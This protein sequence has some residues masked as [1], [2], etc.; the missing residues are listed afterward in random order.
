MSNT[1]KESTPMISPDTLRKINR[2]NKSFYDSHTKKNFGRED[3]LGSQYSGTIENFGNELLLETRKLKMEKPSLDGVFYVNNYKYYFDLKYSNMIETYEQQGMI[4]AILKKDVFLSN[5]EYRIKFED[6]EEI[7]VPRSESWGALNDRTRSKVFKDKFYHT[8]TPPVLIIKDNSTSDVEEIEL[9]LEPYEGFDADYYF[10]NE[11]ATQ[12]FIDTYEDGT[13]ITTPITND[14]AELPFVWICEEIFKSLPPVDFEGNDPTGLPILTIGVDGHNVSHIY[15]LIY[16]VDVLPEQTEPGVWYIIAKSS[17]EGF[18]PSNLNNYNAKVDSIFYMFKPDDE[19]ISPVEYE[20]SYE[21]EYIKISLSDRVNWEIIRETLNSPYYAR[22]S[23]DVFN[24]N[25]SEDSRTILTEAFDI[26]FSDDYIFNPYEGLCE[27]SASGI[28][29][30]VTSEYS[31]NSVPTTNGIIHKL[32]EFDGLPSYFKTMHDYKTHRSHVELYTIRDRFNRFTQNTMDKQTSA[33]ILDSSMPQDDVDNIITDQ[34]PAIIYEYVPGEFVYTTDMDKVVSLKNVL[35]EITYNGESVFGNCNIPSD[36]NKPKFIY[37]GNGVFSLN[38]IEFDSEIET[39]RVYGIT[40]DPI[41]YVNNASVEESMP[42]RTAARMCDIPTTYEQLIHVENISPTYVFD[43][44][45]VRMQ[46]GFWYD[47]LELLMNKRNFKIPMIK[48]GSGNDIWIYPYPSALPSKQILIENGYYNTTNIDNDL[49]QITSDNFR[50]FSGGTNYSIGDT[51][52][53]MLGGKAY[54][55]EV[56][57]VTISGRVSGFDLSIP[58]DS[59]VSIYNIDGTNTT[60]KTATVNT[61]NGTGLILELVISQSD[62]TDHSL[63]IDT[64]NPPENMISFAYDLFDNIFMYRLQSDWT[65]EM[66][67]Q[68]EGSEFRNN[69][70]D[71]NMDVMIRSFNYAFNKLIFDKDY[72]ANDQIFFDQINNIEKKVIVDYDGARGHKGDTET[73]DL[74]QYITDQNMPNTLYRLICTDDS[75]NGHFNLEMFEMKSLDDYIDILPRFNT[76]N[77]K[78]YYNPSNRFIVSNSNTLNTIQPTLFIYSP[79]HNTRIDSYDTMTDTVLIKSSHITNYN[80][81]GEGLI[82]SSGRL[83][84]NIYYYPEYEFS[85][86]YNTLK[87]YLSSLQRNELLT[88]I[89]DN[90]GNDSEVFVYEDGNYKYTE[91]EL[92]NYIMDRY[93][94]NG[95]YLKDGL[96]IHGYAGDIAIDTRTGLPKGKPI[97]GGIVPLTSDVIDTNVVADRIKMSSEPINIFIIDDDTF[98]GFDDSF[99]IHD[100]N[101][102]DITSTSVVIWD[103]NKYIFRNAWIQLTKQIV[104]GYYNPSDGLFYYDLNY[105]NPITP[106]SDIIYHDL[107]SGQYYKWNGANYI[108]ITI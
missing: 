98:S 76:N 8:T 50:I 65:W 79:S 92:V 68:V 52:Y 7:Y 5:K 60:L 91:S 101:G 99:R 48:D 66:V 4:E 14:N 103:N 28:H 19:S 74:S 45:Y 18:N 62:V 40:N 6:C 73:A 20:I 35:T 64:I 96:K 86:A 2:L 100:E 55:G 107:I 21:D 16:G 34:D 81:Y 38:A 22:I 88:Y 23:M 13:L 78:K 47:D 94:L 36:K 25:G 3:I 105:M 90:I 70:Y 30:D 32:C 59:K 9:R 12:K 17:L 26:S 11:F 97:T 63:G 67:C 87:N 80:D 56:T 72:V 61:E 33:L 54:D 1:N 43:Q 84:Y 93:P 44:K 27:G 108:I 58:D 85:E 31:E 41:T 51:F 10:Y 49:I 39:A 102:I 95:P 15:P 29:V 104:N 24:D 37:H 69:P 106:D 89:R 57:S 77:T 46:C 82:N 75:D 83:D 42:L 53:I 71:M